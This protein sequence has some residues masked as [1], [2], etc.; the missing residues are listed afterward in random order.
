MEA[1]GRV[2]LDTRA[3]VR[4]EAGKA[5]GEVLTLLRPLAY[6]AFGGE[7]APSCAAGTGAG[8]SAG[9]AAFLGRF[10]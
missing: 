3:A 4:S 6:F 5:T 9:V 1:A 2:L 8:G 7:S 10:F